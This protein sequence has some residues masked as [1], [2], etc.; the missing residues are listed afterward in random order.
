MQ[1][2]DVDA[3]ATEILSCMEGRG[4]GMLRVANCRRLA[5]LGES[6][7]RVDL[8]EDSDL[9]SFVEA[10]VASTG[11]VASGRVGND[12]LARAYL[13][14]ALAFFHIRDRPGGRLN[15]PD[16]T[17]LAAIQRAHAGKG[18]VN[19]EGPT[20]V[21][22]LSWAKWRHDVESGGHTQP[23]R[24]ATSASARAYGKGRSWCST[25]RLGHKEAG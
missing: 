10:A 18:L 15:S 24:A 25:G 12:S 21:A 3:I 1:P 20:L 16:A 5:Q 22:R 11:G 17:E 9:R 6:T 23:N 4:A 14:G 13:A 8:S 19:R 2:A 7:L